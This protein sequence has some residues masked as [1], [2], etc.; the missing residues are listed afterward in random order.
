ML[1]HSSKRKTQVSY[2]RPIA[3]GITA[4]IIMALVLICIVSAVFSLIENIAKEAVGPI[5]LVVIAAACFCASYICAPSVGKR[6]WIAG[7]II[8][9]AVFL[10]IVIINCFCDGLNFGGGAMIKFFIFVISGACG[11]YIGRNKRCSRRR[12]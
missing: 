10:I 3:I 12:K 2:V 1:T 4:A 6:G 7:G 9:C 11:G 5:V 8:G